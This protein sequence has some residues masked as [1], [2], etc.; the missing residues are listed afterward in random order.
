MNLLLLKFLE[1]KNLDEDFQKIK[2][3]HKISM[4]KSV[5]EAFGEWDEDFQKTRLEKH[6]NE[7][8]NTLKFIEFKNETIGT[9]NFRY[10]I[11][12]DKN[13]NFIEQFYLLPEFQRKGI[14]S[15]VFNFKL[16]LDEQNCETRLSVLKNDNGAQ[17]FYF[18]HGFKEYSE[19]RY[20]KYLQKF[21]HPQLNNTKHLICI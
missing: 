6:F 11:T 15:Y 14:G 16:N 7:S 4:F 13:F 12:E 8:F 9:I 19:D 20:Q 10:K 5:S 1:V 17:K 21:P 18:N 2:K 3:I